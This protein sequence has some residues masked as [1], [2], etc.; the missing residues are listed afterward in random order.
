[1]TGAFSCIK[2][3][4]LKCDGQI[5]ARMNDVGFYSTIDR[6]F[7]GQEIKELIDIPRIGSCDVF[8][9]NTAGTGLYQIKSATYSGTD[10]A[11]KFSSLLVNSTSVC[12]LFSVKLSDLFLFLKS[13]QLPLF[14]MPDVT[15][16][17][18]WNTQNT[19][20]EGKIAIFDSTFGGARDV[21]ISP[22]NQLLLSDHYIYSHDQMNETIKVMNSPNGLSL[23]YEDIICIKNQTAATA[24]PGAGLITT[25]V[26]NKRLGLA[27]KHVR[28]LM[29]HDSLPGVAN[30]LLG[31]YASYSP[32]IPSSVNF[33]IND[34]TLL[35]R[36]LVS[37][38]RKAIELANT[39]NRMFDTLPV[40]Y[41]RD[42]ITDKTSVVR[43]K[44]QDV[45]TDDT[46]LK[47]SQKDSLQAGCHVTGIDLSV[48]DLNVPGSGTLIGTKGIDFQRT[49]YRTTASRAAI[50]SRV[51]AIYERIFN[52]K[53]GLVS[54]SA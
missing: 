28:A 49:F 9:T 46:F 31:Y 17:I 5:I 45:V 4:V 3:A 50:D 30:G 14:A 29:I 37:N 12:P 54:V 23:V 22:V 35:S 20:E 19:N 10:C 42:P 32:D 43:A 21:F 53:S 7:R 40:I 24:D 11:P 8:E 25:L 26:D 47:L 52:L 16:E 41:S 48:L 13:K 39:R 1:M 18:S 38:T 2:D 15:V 51:Y 44:N 34:K 33:S 6:L 27:G 36:P